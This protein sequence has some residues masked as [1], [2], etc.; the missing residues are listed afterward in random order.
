MSPPVSADDHLRHLLSHPGNGLQ[1]LNLMRPRLAGLDN[2]RVQF[3]H[4]LLDQIQPTQHRAGQPG[5]VG[6][7]MAGQRLRQIRDLAPHPTLRQIG[8]H[9]RV[10][11]AVDHRGQHRPGRHRLQT[12][13]YR[14]KFDAGVFQ[15]QL[16]PDDVSAPVAHQ[17]HPIPGQHPQPTDLRRRHERRRQQAVL[18]QLRDPL[19][20]TNVTLPPGHSL[21]MCAAFNSH[22]SITSSRQ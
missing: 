6:V 11:F 4:G 21:H 8:Q 3:S 22:T 17:L 16:Q 14:G 10:G 18:Q 15:H 13:R 9:Q 1:Q 12:G 2:D 7:E 5:M 20:V 19:R